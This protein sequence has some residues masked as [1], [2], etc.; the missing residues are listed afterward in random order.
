MFRVG[1]VATE[2]VSF[3]GLSG[4]DDGRSPLSVDVFNPGSSPLELA[5]EI[6]PE[7]WL[8]LEPGWNSTPVPPGGSRTLRLS[9]RRFR[10]PNGSAL[11]RYTYLTLRTK[12]GATSR[13]LVQDN[14]APLL[15]SGRG[16]LAVRPEAS[17][18]VPSVAHV[19]SA[20]GNTFVSRLSLS[21]AGTEAVQAELVFTPASS[22]SSLVDG[23]DTTA[24]KRATVLV[25]P[26]DLVRLSDPLVLLFG[27]APPVSGTLEVRAPAAR[28]GFLSVSSSVDAPSRRGRHL[29]L[30]PSRLPQRRGDPRR[31]LGGHH[32]RRLRRRRADEPDP[33][34]NDG[35]RLGHR[36]VSLVDVDGALRGS[37]AVT[38]PRW[39]Q[40]QLSRVVERLRGSFG[41][42]AARLEVSVES[43]GG[44]LAAVTTVVDNAN[45][46]ASSFRA[47]P[48][49]SPSIAF[50]TLRP[51]W[52]T[53][54]GTVKS[55]VPSLVNGYQTFPSS[56]APFTFRSVMGF[57]SIA[58]AD[59][60]FRLTY[61][62]LA[63]GKTISREVRVPGRKTVEYANV[64]EE[65]FGI[66]AGARSQGPLFV[67]YGE[68]GKL[69][70]RVAS[71]LADGT[72][73]DSFPVDPRPLRGTR[74]A[75]APP[76]SS[77]S[78]ASSSP[79]TGPAAPARTSSSTRPPGSPSPSSSP[80][81]RPA[82]ALLPSPPA[83]SPSPPSRSSSSPPSSPSSGSTR[84]TAGRTARTSSAPSAPSP[85]TASPP[86]RHDHRQPDRR[87]P[88]PPPRTDGAAAG[89]V[90]IEF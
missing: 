68:H 12:G 61:Y 86:P 21:N 77:P 47:S 85:A 1:G 67:E 33:R 48:S 4:P 75:P 62:D 2:Y 27:L 34:G 59:A 57:T 58:A 88:Q 79:S 35:G 63:S 25:P 13:L 60:L 29:R 15:S 28:A 83:R 55:L 14:E 32:R 71:S 30:R 3:P 70:C 19:T 17:F 80:S 50:R 23:F 69:W 87:H 5:A 20:L 42:R 52:A 54:T 36:K 31:L 74:P 81:T 11:P 72:I 16:P 18:L 9:T 24:I 10:A 53:A 84:T 78:T 89:G 41:S 40:R 90:S 38:V 37:E 49:A 66:G 45:D 51:A 8:S 43:G 56:A 7:V 64:L 76:E 26:N 65:L 6:G 44:T 82:T 46:D 39:G 22:D 73:G